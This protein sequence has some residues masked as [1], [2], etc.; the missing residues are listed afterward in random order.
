MKPLIGITTYPPDSRGYIA[1]PAKYSQAVRRAGGIPLLIPDAEPNLAD[2]LQL[3]N[4]LILSGGGDVDPARY[5]QTAHSAVYG[6]NPVR[7]A[8]EIDLLHHWLQTDKPLLCICR[9]MQVLNVALGGSLIVDIPDQVPTALM[10]R[11]TADEYIPHAVQL[12]PNSRLAQIMGAETVSTASWHHQAVDRLADGLRVV[13]Q[14]ADGIIEAVELA[15]KPNV[16]AVQWHPEI[17]AAE[18][19]SQQCLFNTL[20]AHA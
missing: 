19:V 6:V 2:L 8:F 5:T 11:R 16:L 15:D 20:V 4:G 14:A 1:S 12:A 13:G 18:D 3:L 7:D 9:G 17:T 10:H